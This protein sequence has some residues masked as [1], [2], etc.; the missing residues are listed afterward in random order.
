M[1]TRLTLTTTV[2]LLLGLTTAC[3]TTEPPKTPRTTT[4]EPT[5]NPTPHDTTDLVVDLTWNQQ[6][7]TE[8]DTLCDGIN[9]LGTEWAADEMQAGAGDDSLDWDRAAVL[10]EAKCALR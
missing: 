2:A 10:V 5:P 7:E 8:K 6:T 3:T 9:L 1:N 4:V